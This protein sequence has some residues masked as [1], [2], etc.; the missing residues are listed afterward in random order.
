MAVLAVDEWAVEHWQ[1][2]V[3]CSRCHLPDPTVELRPA[4]TAYADQSLN[5]P[6]L[7]CE[8]CAVEYYDYWNE[9]WKEY[10]QS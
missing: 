6:L 3:P 2:M 1:L 8:L 7:L 4:M 10:R 9:L 5:K